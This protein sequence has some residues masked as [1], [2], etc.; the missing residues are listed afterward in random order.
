MEEKKVITLDLTGC[1][2]LGELH[3][4]IRKDFDFP[5]FYGKNWNA[6]WDLLRSDCDA[7]KVIV[8]GMATLP[9]E[10]EQE[11]EKIVEILQ[12]LKKHRA[13]YGEIIEIE[14]RD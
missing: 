13:R 3:Q 8:L 4:R 2:N 14:I 6:F 1:K 5:A 12:R 10:F 9:N 11:K 7:D